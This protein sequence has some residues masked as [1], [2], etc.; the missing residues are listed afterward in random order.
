MSKT[1]SINLYYE[2]RN[3]STK[4]AKTLNKK[5]FLDNELE[6]GDGRDYFTLDF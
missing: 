2:S 4:T 5:F 6:I 3:T 1:I